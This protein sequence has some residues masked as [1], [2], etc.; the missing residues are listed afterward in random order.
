MRF[1]WNVLFVVVIV[2][3]L[4]ACVSVKT[5]IADLTL[6]STKSFAENGIDVE[7][8]SNS[9]VSG[10]SIPMEMIGVFYYAGMP[11]FEDAID[12]A[13]DKTDADALIDVKIKQKVVP[14]FPIY[15]ESKFVV[16]GT[17]VKFKKPIGSE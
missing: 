13:L 5:R 1:K 6:I 2:L 3:G 16:E 15:F 12:S 17:P 8:V 14:L 4:S 7:K 11:D 9:S 10:A